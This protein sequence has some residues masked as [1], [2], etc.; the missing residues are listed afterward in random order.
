ML[1]AFQAPRIPQRPFLCPAEKQPAA[2][3]HICSYLSVSPHISVTAGIVPRAVYRERM[4]KITMRSGKA[5]AAGLAVILM[6]I[7]RTGPAA[8]ASP[9]GYIDGTD[10]QAI[11]G[12]AWDERQPDRPA[13][14]QILVTNEADN[15]IVCAE[16][17]TADRY[18]DDLGHLG[19][20]CHAF[21]FTPQLPDT[22]PASFIITA[23]SGGSQL[24]GSLYWGGGSSAVTERPSAAAPADSQ[25]APD[26]SGP[27]SAPQQP[28]ILS[29]DEAPSVTGSAEAYDAASAELSL[30]PLGLFTTTAYCS[31]RRC[32]GRWGRLTSSGAIAAA[33][34]TVAVDPRVIPYGTRLM[35]DGIL[36][37]A[38]DEGSGVK[39]RHIDIYFDTHAEA[40]AY[41]LQHREVYL[42][43]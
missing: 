23:T 17:V 14:V 6:I 28:D 5:I 40:A 42:V 13:E 9:A 32:S 33:G 21:C 2:V 1:R 29:G 15:S 18:R 31:C 39:G 7:S 16:T 22:G 25:T 20:G 26:P 37:T 19:N 27:G 35:I 41:G 38:E 36:Y 24:V 34:H 11:W 43:R 3:R 12:W 10:G 8:A 30:T 4:D